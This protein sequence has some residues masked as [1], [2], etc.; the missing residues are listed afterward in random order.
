MDG[1]CPRCGSELL[2]FQNSSQEQFG[3]KPCDSIFVQASKPERA[4]K[5]LHE[6]GAKFSDWRKQQ[7]LSANGIS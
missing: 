6:T 5:V 3:C 4:V 7:V 2:V 1:K